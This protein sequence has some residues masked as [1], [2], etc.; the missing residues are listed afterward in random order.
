MI[1]TVKQISERLILEEE[2]QRDEIKSSNSQ[3]FKELIS[4]AIGLLLHSMQLEVKEALNLL[5]LIRLGGDLGW[6]KNVD[7]SAIDQALMSTRR[8]HLSYLNPGNEPIEK[9]RVSFLHQ[10]LQGIEM[11]Q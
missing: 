1:A 11:E 3:Q 4:R 8:A 5:S 7:K 6:I 10:K 9:R 2:M